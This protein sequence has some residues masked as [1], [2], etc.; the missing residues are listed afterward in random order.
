M[1]IFSLGKKVTA[2]TIFRAHREKERERETERERERGLISLMILGHYSGYKN[3]A[4]FR[5]I[6]KTLAS[7]IINNIGESVRRI[8]PQQIPF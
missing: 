2:L 4:R 7:T 5:F 6:G 3:M 8:S 1:P